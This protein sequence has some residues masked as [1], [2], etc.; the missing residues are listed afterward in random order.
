MSLKE[1]FY[2]KVLYQVNSKFGAPMGRVKVGERPLA[3]TSG[4][5][6]RIFKKNQVKVFDKRVP[7]VDGAYDIGGAYW[8]I[9]RELRVEFTKDLSFIRFYRV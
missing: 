9:G 1:I 3:V 6:C 4:P 5:N 7:M 2:G 8:G